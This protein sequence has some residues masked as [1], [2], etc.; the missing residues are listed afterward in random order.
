MLETLHRALPMGRVSPPLLPHSQSTRS[1]RTTPYQQKPFTYTLI[2]QHPKTAAKAAYVSIECLEQARL[3]PKSLTPCMRKAH[4]GLVIV[5]VFTSPKDLLKTAHN[6]FTIA[7]R[8]DANEG[9]STITAQCRQ[10]LTLCCHLKD[11]YKLLTKTQLIGHHATLKHYIKVMSAMS[12][13]MHFSWKLLDQAQ[14]TD[15]STRQRPPYT[16]HQKHLNVGD[17]LT[18]LMIAGILLGQ[19]FNQATASNHLLPWLQAGTVVF[20]LA[21]IAESINQ[22]TNQLFPSPCQR[23]MAG[24]HG[25][26]QATNNNAQ[27]SMHDQG[28]LV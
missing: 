13:L 14:G 11:V 26:D 27:L 23:A 12:M 2:T 9:S 19:I 25:T 7:R 5:K 18:H 3:I 20:S 21:S 22:S 28:K 6:M 8:Q 24:L 15:A 16:T 10:L 17:A 4:T 1:P